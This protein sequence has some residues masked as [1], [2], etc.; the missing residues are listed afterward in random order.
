MPSW[1]EP[2]YVVGKERPT[3]NQRMILVESG[4]VMPEA[5]VVEDERGCVVAVMENH[6]IAPVEVNEGQGGRGRILSGEGRK[7]CSSGD[8]GGD[9]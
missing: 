6:G 1:S 3:L 8:S 5:A 7:D 4:V 9:G 2:R